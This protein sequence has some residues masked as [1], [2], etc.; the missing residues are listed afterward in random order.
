[1]TLQEIKIDKYNV[2]KYFE[3]ALAYHMRS[4]YKSFKLWTLFL[5]KFISIHLKRR[6]E[7][8]VSQ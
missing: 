1:M 3:K 5:V 2:Y 4:G 8:G 6:E 7:K